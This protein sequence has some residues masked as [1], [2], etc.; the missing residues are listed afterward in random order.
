MLI[1][2]NSQKNTR[3]CPY[4]GL[5]LGQRRSYCLLVC[6]TVLWALVLQVG[7]EGGGGNEPTVIRRDELITHSELLTSTNWFWII[8][9]YNYNTGVL[10]QW[11]YSWNNTLIG[12][13]SGVL[14]P[15]YPAGCPA[16]PGCLTHFAADLSSTCDGIMHGRLSRS[17]IRSG[18]IISENWLR[19]G[20]SLHLNLD[21]VLRKWLSYMWKK[22]YPE[23]TRL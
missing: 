12:P 8:Y 7:G 22:T 11:N 10:Y 6:T 17:H 20:R 23:H 13:G 3:H 18:E 19:T 5:M 9:N 2:A 1:E 4:V 14:F 16:W 15:V 21:M